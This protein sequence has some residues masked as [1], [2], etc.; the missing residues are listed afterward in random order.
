M[1]AGMLEVG[2][3]VGCTECLCILQFAYL[4]G[5]VNTGDREEGGNE[6]HQAPLPTAER[7]SDGE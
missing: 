2:H 7:N 4:A 6:V 3:P 5:R 1:L